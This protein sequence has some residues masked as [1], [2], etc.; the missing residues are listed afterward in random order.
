MSWW[1]CCK[2]PDKDQKKD[3][4]NFFSQ[5]LWEMPAEQVDIRKDKIYFVPDRT[6]E[7]RRLHFLRNGVYLGDLKKKRFE[8]SQPFALALSKD[9]FTRC[10]HFSAEDQRLQRYLKGESFSVDDL[11]PQENG[12]YLVTAA[13][14]P[15]GFGKVAGNT[16]KNKYPVGWR[17]K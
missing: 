4:E 12:W 7:N 10:L 14:Y 9:T 5:V 15:L 11:S 1:N 8:P 2:G 3:L 6:Q 16:L 13:G 17:K